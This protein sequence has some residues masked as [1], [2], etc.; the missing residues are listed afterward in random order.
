MIK[1]NGT[2]V[3]AVF[4]V[5]WMGSIL[6]LLIPISYIIHLINFSNAQKLPSYFRNVQWVNML[7]DLCVGRVGG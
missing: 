1:V 3:H 6:L 4:Q 7:K 2:H 5:C